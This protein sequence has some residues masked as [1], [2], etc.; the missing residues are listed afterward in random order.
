MTA[1]PQRASPASSPAPRQPA[2]Q[3]T[4]PAGRGAAGISPAAS[5]AIAR[6][7]QTKGAE[8]KQKAPPAT[9][10]K[11]G[12]ADAKKPA[13]KASSPAVADPVEA[14]KQ[15]GAG[16]E[17]SAV[18]PV[19]AVAAGAADAAGGTGAAGAEKPGEAKA[20][21]EAKGEAKKTRQ[22]LATV[23]Q[24]S[25]SQARCAA[26]LK[27]ALVDEA[28]TAR[29]H[30]LREARKKALDEKNTEQGA[31][32]KNQ[33]D[34]LSNTMVRLSSDTSIAIAVLLDTAVKELFRFGL[35]KASAGKHLMDIPNLHEKGVEDLPCF[36]LYGPLP[37]FRDFK[38]ETE[39]ARRK[40][41]AAAK[42]A[43]EAKRAAP[44]AAA[45]EGEESTKTSFNTYVEAALREVKRATGKTSTRSA[46]ELRS[47]VAQLVAD[48]IRR[49][50]DLTKILVVHVA[51]ART[52]TADNVKAVV[53]ILFVDAG[54]APAEIDRVLAAVDEKLQVHHRHQTDEKAKKAD[55]LSAEA[56]E[57]AALKAAAAAR[58]R[59]ARQL[60]SAQRRAQEAS[61][62][63]AKLSNEL[64]EAAA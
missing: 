9:P 54:R 38:P 4:P 3:A 13:A 59:K 51:G 49:L 6:A 22:Q 20:K 40:A 37:A 62:K 10:P 32:L 50:A 58:E 15:P 36:P 46:A 28:T 57:A 47:Y 5:A 26:H 63:A 16:P 7:Q 41:R 19:S 27:K 45:E 21:G 17:A 52:M 24:I 42:A 25:I 35:E 53:R 31:S 2:A 30:E 18:A 56:R 29:L 44:A 8:A 64:G 1:R 43:R 55:N 60:A 23:L 39:D 14:A 61:E 12:P 34:D 33:I 48:V 11:T